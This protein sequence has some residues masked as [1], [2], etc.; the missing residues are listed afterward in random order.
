MTPTEVRAEVYAVLGVDATTYAGRLP[1]ATIDLLS[2]RAQCEMAV[3]GR[4]GRLRKTNQQNLTAATAE[5]KM[6]ADLL[7]L[8]S[9]WADGTRL[10]QRTEEQ[11]D[12][13]SSGWREAG[14][15]NS[16]Q[17]RYYYMTGLHL[18]ND[19]DYGKRL[20]KL[21]PV[22]DT[23]VTNGLECLYI[24]KPYKLA[25]MPSASVEIIDIPEEHHEAIV[26]Y[27]A[28]KFLGRQG[29]QA[30]QDFDRYQ[31]LWQKALAEFVRD[32]N[33]VWMQDNNP[34]VPDRVFSMADAAFSMWAE[35]A[36]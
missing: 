11:V 25:S 10:D 35:G 15:D 36:Y 32:Q 26:F 19:S 9:L 21:W 22:P 14:A 16:G 13:L 29:E 3:A 17:A 1:T 34:V 28:W 30:R 20:V 4:P 6:P 18:T 24:R 31:G 2:W 8:M 12:E 23:T 27:I 5:Y 7:T 33:E